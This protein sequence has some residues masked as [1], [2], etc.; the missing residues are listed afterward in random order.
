M[1]RDLPAFLLSAAALVLV[2][3][4]GGK[5]IV[6]PKPENPKAVADT[7]AGPPLRG[8]VTKSGDTL[9]LRE[10]GAAAEHPMAVGDPSGELAKAYA[11]LATPKGDSLDVELRGAQS[12][13][14]ASFA[15]TELVRARVLHGGASCER[16][17]FDGD[18]LVNGNEPFWTV[19]IKPDGIVY[20]SPEVPKGRAYP[21]AMTR[22]ETGASV[23]ATRIDKP[24]V[25]T[26]EISLEP[27]RCVDSMSGEIRSVKGHVALDGRKLEGCAA[28]GI[29]R[30][31]FG[32][33]PLDELNRFAG[34]YPDEATLWGSPSIKPRLDALLGAK[35][36]IFL[37]N[38]QVRSPVKRDAGIFYVT[39]NKAH[40]GG[41]DNAIFV[42]DPD[43]DT[44][45][46]VLFVN[47]V[48]EDFAEG[49]RDVPF[50]AEVKKTIEGLEHR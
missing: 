11:A 35:A 13:D 10:C 17:V 27:G 37:E 22:T 12:A 26:L 31:G 45:V 36:K 46:V 50:P 49:G 42:A 41:V 44:I 5:T 30:G 28:A 34:S 47:G 29:P 21:Y 43:S 40:Q 18:Y 15:M 2:A 38:M 1:R 25:S 3:C 7:D 48:R 14:G 6:A 23:Y 8:T 33:A 9:E 32:D 24:Q 20:R 39:G 4:G 19:E 16:P